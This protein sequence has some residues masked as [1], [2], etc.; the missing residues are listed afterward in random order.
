MYHFTG[1]LKEAKL[2][3]FASSTFLTDYILVKASELAAATR[4]LR[5]AGW[6]VVDPSG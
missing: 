6:T 5:E 4:A 3:M 1:P 2:S